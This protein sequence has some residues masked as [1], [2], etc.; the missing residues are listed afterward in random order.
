MNE[1]IICNCR[2]LRL[3]GLIHSSFSRDGIFKIKREERAR[4]VKSFHMEKLP[5]FD[6]GGADMDDDIFLDPSQ[7]ANASVAI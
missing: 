2:N 7:V 1:S 3:D 5:D 6:F 4:F